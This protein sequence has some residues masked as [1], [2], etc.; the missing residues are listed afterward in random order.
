MKLLLAAATTALA[1]IIAIACTGDSNTNTLTLEHYFAELQ[2][3][4]DDAEERFDEIEF[5]D[6][7]ADAS[8]EESRDALADFFDAS[9]DVSEDAIDDIR[10]LNPPDEAADEH[11]AFVDALEK[12]PSAT[13]D[14]ADRI[15]EAED[16]DEY[17]DIVGDEDPLETISS[18]IDE[19]CVALQQ[20]ADDNSIEVD[21]ECDE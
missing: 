4:T 5:P 19:A 1:A 21:L 3:I 20:I 17:N 2:R 8:F 15:R 11:D 6:V 13:G 9:T 12:L 10:N 16:E 14:Y 18:E 7:A